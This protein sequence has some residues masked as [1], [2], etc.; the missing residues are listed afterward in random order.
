[1]HTHMIK[2]IAPAATPNQ[3]NCKIIATNTTTRHYIYYNYYIDITIIIILLYIRR[4]RHVSMRPLH[5]YIGI[6]IYVLIAP[7]HITQKY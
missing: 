7:T 5:A 4:V 3:N 2:I 6:I 1:V